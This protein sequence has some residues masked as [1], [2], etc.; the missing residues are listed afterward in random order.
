MVDAPGGELDIAERRRR[1]TKLAEE[2][3][4]LT[5]RE[6]ERACDAGV[7]CGRV[8]VVSGRRYDLARKGEAWSCLDGHMISRKYERAFVHVPLGER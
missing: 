5:E 2:R 3:A 4:Q 1:A 8:T 6:D 7:L